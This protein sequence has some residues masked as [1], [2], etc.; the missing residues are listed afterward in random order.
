MSIMERWEE[1]GKV[2]QTRTWLKKEKK[3]LQNEEER[4]NTVESEADKE[5]KLAM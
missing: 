3:N 2:I 4:C 5:K 1:G